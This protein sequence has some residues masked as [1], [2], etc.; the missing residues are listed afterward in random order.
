MLE[1]KD[2]T[3][4]TT[5]GK[6]LITDL[7]LV[8]NEDDKL[9][10]IGEEGNG[11]ST[12]LKAI[13]NSKEVEKYCNLSGEINKDDLTIGYLEQSLN[14]DWNNQYIYE[15]FLKNNPND[16]I[17]YDSYEKLNDA[18]IEL[19]KIGVKP[20]ILQSELFNR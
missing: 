16:E 15:Y 17:A 4:E 6:P 12:L 18:A 14:P 3:I 9:A 1:I 20:E 13:Y 7:N 19:S 10:V 11:K 2:L 8:L 5:K